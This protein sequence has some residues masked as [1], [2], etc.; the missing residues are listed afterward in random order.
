[1]ARGRP[2]AFDLARARERALRVF[3]RKGFEGTTLPDL[4]KAWGINSP[5]LAGRAS[6]QEL[7]GVVERALRAWPN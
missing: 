5:S 3:W 2:R 4:T 6:R 1:M 7:R